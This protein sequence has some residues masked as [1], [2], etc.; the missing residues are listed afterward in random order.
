MFLKPLARKNQSNHNVCISL[1]RKKCCYFGSADLYFPYS[2]QWC[3]SE[4]IQNKF[5]H[6]L[7]KKIGKYLWMQIKPEMEKH[8]FVAQL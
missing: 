1:D 6:V 3:N 4:Q 7:N 8:D 5:V 2:D